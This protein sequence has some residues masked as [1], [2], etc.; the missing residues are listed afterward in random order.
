M[1]LRPIDSVS[2][3]LS[4]IEQI[5]RS[6][7]STGQ[8]PLLFYR[9]LSQAEFYLKAAVMRCKAHRKNEGGML[10]ELMTRRPDE[11]SN[12]SSALDRWMFAQ[13]HG[14]YTRFLD[15]SPNPLVGL[16]FACGGFNDKTDCSGVLYLFSTVRSHVKPYDSDSVSV[17]GNF[18]RL[19]R[20][21]QKAILKKTKEFLSNRN[22]FVD[23][24]RRIMD[25]TVGRSVEEV[26]DYGAFMDSLRRENEA[27]GRYSDMGR[28]WTFVK[29]E[30]P[31]FVEGLIDPRD[32]FRIFIVQ[33]KLLFPR[34]RAQSGAF[35]VSAYHDTFDFESDERHERN[36]RYRMENCDVPYDYCRMTVESGSKQAILD[37]LQALNISKESLFPEVETS[38]KA[39]LQE[40]E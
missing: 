34:V 6:E 38:A 10:R 32:L 20:T 16:F 31:Y 15:I 12:L 21:E 22:A 27:S 11:F 25:R 30:K 40:N 2:R 24:R 5:R 1:E 18:A 17:I 7:R 28:L 4:N 8:E 13:H 19:R 23:R 36:V 39:I 9:G 3:L 37:E 26:K 29:Q 35:L 33:P 14:L